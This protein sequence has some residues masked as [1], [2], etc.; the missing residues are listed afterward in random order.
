MKKIL[1]G[2]GILLALVLVLALILPFIVDLNSYQAQ[3]RPV[4]EETLNRKVML[5]DIR[6]TIIPRIGVRIAGFTV[7][8]DPAFGEQPF[9]SLSS[10]DIGVK[11]GP[12]LQK[13]VEVEEINHHRDQKPPRCLEHC[14][15]GE[16]G[17][18]ETRSAGRTID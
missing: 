7:M 13:R 6:L 18:A 8:D 11:L 2:I 9:A 14:H 4:I 16:K 1:L 5:K 12:L 17:P 3:Y 10:L 15:L